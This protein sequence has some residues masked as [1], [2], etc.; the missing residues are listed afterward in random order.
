MVSPSKLGYQ[1]TATSVVLG[2]DY[3]PKITTYQCTH[4]TWATKGKRTDTEPEIPEAEVLPR[5]VFPPPTEPLKRTIYRENFGVIDYNQTGQIYK[6][7]QKTA[8]IISTIHQLP[9]V[10]LAPH[11]DL[12]NCKTEPSQQQTGF[13]NTSGI[14]K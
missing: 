5:S 12:K 4:N 7:Q 11:E 3:L 14:S 8:S 6:Q 9:G 10:P 13:T 2:N 1:K